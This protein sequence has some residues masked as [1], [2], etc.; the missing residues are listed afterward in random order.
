MLP[1]PHRPTYHR[2]PNV[3]LTRLAGETFID[4]APSADAFENCLHKFWSTQ[5]VKAKAKARDSYIAG[6][7]KPDQPQFTART[8]DAVT[9]H[10]QNA[11]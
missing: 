2:L 1:P 6:S 4:T 3:S 5:E 9:K 7:G 11:S 8:N 10:Y